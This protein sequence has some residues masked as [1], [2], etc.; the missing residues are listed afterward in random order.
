M[1]V[2]E[3]HIEWLALDI[4]DNIV[5]ILADGKTIKELRQEGAAGVPGEDAALVSCPVAR[6][7]PAIVDCDVAPAFLDEA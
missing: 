5:F 3:R 2:N 6:I 4:L 7:A 1:R